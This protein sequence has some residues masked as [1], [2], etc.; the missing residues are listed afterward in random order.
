MDSWRPT[1]TE[2]QHKLPVFLGLICFP[3]L[4][5]K[6]AYLTTSLSRSIFDLMKKS[7]HRFSSFSVSCLWQVYFGTSNG[8]V[9][10]MDVHGVMLS[11]VQ[12]PSDSPISSMAWSCEKFKMEESEDGE[13]TSSS[14]HYCNKR[15][16]LLAVCFKTGGIYLMKSYDDVAPIYISTGM[17]VR[18]LEIPFINFCSFRWRAQFPNDF[19]ICSV[20]FYVYWVTRAMWV[21]C[22]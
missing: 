15:P 10:V 18:F 7:T 9:V 4:F 13:A 16:F 22:R 1:G 21:V 8:Q 14:N 11:Q 20:N 17:H 3:L 6:P 19:F 12:L 5:W 2:T